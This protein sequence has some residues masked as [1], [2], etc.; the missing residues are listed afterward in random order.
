MVLKFL[1]SFKNPALKLF[2]SQP[3]FIFD[4]VI[5]MTE[6]YLKLNSFEIFLHI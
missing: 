2:L 4:L 3:H 1:I 5:L 6:G